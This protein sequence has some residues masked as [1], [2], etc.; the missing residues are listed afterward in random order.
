[1]SRAMRSIHLYLP[2]F[3]VAGNMLVRQVFIPETMGYFRMNEKLIVYRLLLDVMS[4]EDWNL[5]HYLHV[6]LMSKRLSSLE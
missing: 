2:C 4:A 1:M 5:F 3:L 6:L